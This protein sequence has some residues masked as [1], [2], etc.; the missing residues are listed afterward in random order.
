V[1]RAG[2]RAEIRRLDPETEKRPGIPL[3][4]PGHASE[5]SAAIVH[6][7]SPEASYATGSSFVVDGGLTLMAAIL[8]PQAAVNGGSHPAVLLAYGGVLVLTALGSIATWALTRWTVDGGDLR[9]EKGV[10]RRQSRRRRTPQ[11]RRLLRM[12]RRSQCT[13]RRPRSRL[14]RSLRPRSPPTPQVP[15]Q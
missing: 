13:Q 9:I 5:I 15:T 3:G 2:R 1:E 11:C 14:S 12:Q 8:A 6:L 7:A 4:R 10:L